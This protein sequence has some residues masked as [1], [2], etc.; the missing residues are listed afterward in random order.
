MSYPCKG[1]K[2]SLHNAVMIIG[3]NLK[4]LDTSKMSDLDKLGLKA[5]LEC[6][7]YLVEE[8]NKTRYTIY[9]E[10]DDT[11]DGLAGHGPF[12]SLEEAK[13]RLAEFRSKGIKSTIVS[14]KVLR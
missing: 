9:W 2:P 7:V 11:I 5:A 1:S 10:C 12:D 8:L 3:N 6:F 14:G 13:A 4:A